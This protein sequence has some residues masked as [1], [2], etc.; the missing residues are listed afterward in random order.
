M[1]TILTTYFVLCK[2]N[3]KYTARIIAMRDNANNIAPT[4]Y[5]YE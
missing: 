3:N 2:N 4:Y 1:I 5:D